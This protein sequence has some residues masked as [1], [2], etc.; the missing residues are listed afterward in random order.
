MR[1][2]VVGRGF[3]GAVTEVCR[4]I[5]MLCIPDYST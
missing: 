2:V 3:D 1:V 5:A 4:G